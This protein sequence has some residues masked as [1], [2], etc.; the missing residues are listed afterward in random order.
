MGIFLIHFIVMK[1]L[2]TI[3]PELYGIA[4]YSSILDFIIVFFFSAFV[5]FSIK[6]IGII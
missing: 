6:K 5:T 4:T 2:N 1:Y 3:W